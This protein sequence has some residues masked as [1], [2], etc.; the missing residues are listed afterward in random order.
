MRSLLSAIPFFQNRAPFEVVPLQGQGRCNTTYRVA[1]KKGSYIVRKLQRSD[2]DRDLEW[3]IQHLAYRAGLTAKPLL[4][5]QTYG[6]MVFALL[7][8]QHRYTLSEAALQTLAR[9]LRTLHQIPLKMSPIILHTDTTLIECFPKTYTLCH[10]DLNP[11]N[12]LWDNTEVKL[13]DFEYAGVND[14]YFDLASVSVEFGLDEKMRQIFLEAY[15]GGRDFSLEKLSAYM[16]CYCQLC[17][18]W[19]QETLPT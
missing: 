4:F 11:T 7:P 19:Q 2:I 18:A 8:G 1:T 13:I 16:A 5:D 12:L 14:C 6:V 3:Q 10:N 15:F 17:E 9:Q